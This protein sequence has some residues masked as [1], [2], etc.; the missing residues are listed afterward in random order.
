MH[1]D[2]WSQLQEDSPDL[3]KMNDIGAKI[4]MAIT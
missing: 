1:M 4:N 2:F 3:G